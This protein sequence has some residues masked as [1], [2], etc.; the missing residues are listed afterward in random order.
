MID[1]EQDKF[2]DEIISN[3]TKISG[4]DCIYFLSNDYEVI[5]EK[6]VKGTSNYSE[7]ILN[8][9]RPKSFFEKISSDFYSK[10]FHTYTLLNENGLVVISRFFLNSDSE[11]N[12]YLVI[13]AGE[14]EPVDLINLLKICKECRFSFKNLLKSNVI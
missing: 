6:N 7:Q 9:V 14:N 4:V 10:P 2:C 12:L 8:I 3:I 1:P 5:K 13:I 11:D